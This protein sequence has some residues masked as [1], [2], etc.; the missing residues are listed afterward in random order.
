MN[1]YLLME[2][3]YSTIIAGLLFGFAFVKIKSIL[4]KR[5]HKKSSEVNKWKQQKNTFKKRKKVCLE[6]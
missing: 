5:F 4:K 2:A 1:Y 6:Q 3:I